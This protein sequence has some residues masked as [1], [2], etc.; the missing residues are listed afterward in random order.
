M[1]SISFII[2]Y[3]CIIFIIIIISNATKF[4]NNC[5]ASPAPIPIPIPV[6]IPAPLPE[7]LPS[8]SVK[9]ALAQLTGGNLNSISSINIETGHIANITRQHDG[10]I[11][12][13]NGRSILQKRLILY[14]IIL[15]FKRYRYINKNINIIK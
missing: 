12:I 15:Y 13:A 8:P 14:S 1:I 6:P 3:Y 7:P 2:H 4:I 5:K 11:F 9:I 10:D